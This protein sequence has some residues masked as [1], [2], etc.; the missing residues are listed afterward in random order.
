M[1]QTDSVPATVA[2]TVGNT[3]I[4][5]LIVQDQISKIKA[6]RVTL[7][8][9]LQERG[10]KLDA[11]E[12]ELATRIND[13]GAATW[14]TR[15]KKLALLLHE[16]GH[17]SELSDGGVPEEI[18]DTYTL[19]FKY[20]SRDALYLLRRHSDNPWNEEDFANAPETLY[21]GYSH[22]RALKKG[23]QIWQRAL[24]LPFERRS[25]SENLPLSLDDHCK[26]LILEG[27]RIHVEQA[28]LFVERDRID[29]ILEDT[30]NIEKK[31]LAALTRNTLGN[32]PALMAQV[33]QIVATVET[34]MPM[35]EAHP[36][37]EA[38]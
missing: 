22:R 23:G 17:L 9:Q 2:F 8:E 31:V 25:Q 21:V 5:N 14:G 26:Q 38:Q 7:V 32:N 10:E 6:E 16:M 35:L 15:I 30:N 13:I 1:S 29:A 36:T 20:E 28:D 37:V 24:T 12:Q 19:E 3:E 33:S 18:Y 27:R 34:G 11:L 4:T